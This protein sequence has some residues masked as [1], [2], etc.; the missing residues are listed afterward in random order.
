MFSF[1]GNRENI[2]FCWVLKVLD[3]AWLG[4]VLFQDGILAGW[5]EDLVAPTSD[6]GGAAGG[7]VLTIGFFFLTFF[8]IYLN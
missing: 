2:G 4:S 8:F 5:L 1:C 6:G 7:N 3:L